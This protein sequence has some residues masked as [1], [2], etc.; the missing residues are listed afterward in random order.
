MPVYNC[1]EYIS[2]AVE[3]ILRQSFAAL[4]LIIVID[5]TEDDSAEKIHSTIRGDSRCVVINQANLGIGAALNHGI[6]LSRGEFVARMDGDDVSYPE[7][8]QRQYTWLQQN[9]RIIAVGSQVRLVDATGCPKSDQMT[10]PLSHEEIDRWSLERGGGSISHPTLFLRTRDLRR[11]GGY[12]TRHAEDFDLLLRLA[13]I[14]RLANMPEVLLDYR[15]HEKQYSRPYNL[16]LS[17]G[18]VTALRAAGDRR[19][20]RMTHMLAKHYRKLAWQETDQGSRLRGATY[21]MR[22]CCSEFWSWESWRSLA[23]SIVKASYP[24]RSRTDC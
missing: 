18:I 11:I 20:M 21:A 15:V 7:R 9:P 22:S 1:G 2:I 6:A 8:L 17:V 24:Q 12:T 14:G 23:R 3:S 19:K 4:E 5:G 16:N 10:L 13:E